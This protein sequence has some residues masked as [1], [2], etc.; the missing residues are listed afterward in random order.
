[1][2]STHQKSLSANRKNVCI[3]NWNTIEIHHS[4]ILLNTS[5]KHKRQQLLC[6][7]KYQKHVI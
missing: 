6:P 4:D 1:M 5:Y 3:I 7:S 2:L